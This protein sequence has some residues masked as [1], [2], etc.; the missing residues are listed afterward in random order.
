VNA[1][2]LAARYPDT[3]RLDPILGLVKRCS[4]CGEWWT[5]TKQF[6]YPAPGR[7]PT[8]LHSWCI[9]CARENIRERRYG[10][11]RRLAAKGAH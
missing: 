1:A 7:P 6:F 11:R 8:G 10:E 2:E 9:A 4:K 5:A 3:L